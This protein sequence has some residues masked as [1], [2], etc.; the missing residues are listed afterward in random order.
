LRDV[1]T[2]ISTDMETLNSRIEKSDTW[3]F[4]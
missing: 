1:K 2:I 4:H 3:A